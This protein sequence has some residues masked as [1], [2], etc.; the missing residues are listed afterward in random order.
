M[1]EIGHALNLEHTSTNV[2][3]VMYPY[4]QPG[5]IR[6]DLSPNDL[7]GGNRMMDLSTVQLNAC[8]NPIG[9][10]SGEGCGSNSINQTN[11]SAI[12]FYPSPFDKSFTIKPNI[13]HWQSARVVLTDLTGRI[14]YQKQYDASSHNLSPL[15][16]EPDKSLSE[17][18]YHVTL[19]LDEQA[20]IGKIVKT[21]LR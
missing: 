10:Y 18:V 9:Y 8:P 20:F 19:L 7:L 5:S 12:S 2:L 14:V 16:I 13:S 4:Y 11:P 3:E 1:H 15:V 6:R 17:G 21:S